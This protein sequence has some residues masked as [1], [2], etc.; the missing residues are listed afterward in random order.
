MIP[1]STSTVQPAFAIQRRRWRLF[2][3]S[4]DD[5]IRAF[6][7]G[8]AIVAV[9]VLALITYFLFRE[10][11]GFFGQNRENLQIYRQAGLEYV[12]II[13]RAETDHTAL[14]RYLSDLRQRALAYY[15]ASEKLPLA[16]ANAR[17]ADFDAFAG[18]FSDAVEP[19]RGLVSDLTESVT[20]IKTK[21]TVLQDQRE[22][23]R[24]LEAEGRSKEAA[25]IKITTLD[26]ATELKPILGTLPIYKQ[27]SREFVQEL[28][29]ILDQSPAL[30]KE[31]DDRWQKFRSLVRQYIATLPKVE[32]DL[33]A[34]DWRAPMPATRAVTSFIFG[35]E[36]ITASFWQD[37]YGVLPLLVGSLMV[38][39]VALALARR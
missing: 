17:L 6:F 2:G 26:F 4:M 11:A 13:R 36:W 1:P 16:A 37:W 8:N 21:F 38:S 14:S 5:V 19:L 22:E 10:G 7:G 27:T 24:Q 3:L 32:R 25:A 31:L 28:Q 12:D 20:A 23:R 34:W 30:P 15:M 39:A 18:Q 9:V 33:E 29:K 35:R